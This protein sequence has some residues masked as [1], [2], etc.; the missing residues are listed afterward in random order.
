MPAAL[1]PL[2]VFGTILVIPLMWIFKPWVNPKPGELW[3]Y[4][5]ADPFEKPIDYKILDT[6]NGFV[7][8]EVVA[9]YGKS[10]Y[11]PGHTTT[12]QIMY[13][14]NYFKKL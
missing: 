10:P 12:R 13:V 3:Q 6:R 2:L 1:A 8:L 4:Q 9:D 11:Q 14:R 7:L 5:S